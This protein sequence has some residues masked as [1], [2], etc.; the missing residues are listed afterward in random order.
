LYF[1]ASTMAVASPIPLV[2][3]VIKAIFFI[4]KE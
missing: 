1:L 2:A 3:P 4:L